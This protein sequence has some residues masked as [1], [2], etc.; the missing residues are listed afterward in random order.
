MLFD[1]N[2]DNLPTSKDKLIINILIII[3]ILEEILYYKPKYIFK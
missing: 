2:L 1:K 3:D